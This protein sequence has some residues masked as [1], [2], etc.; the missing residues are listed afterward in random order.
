MTSTLPVRT[1]LGLVVII[2]IVAACGG[3]TGGLGSVP[4]SAPTASA[5]PTSPDLTPGPSASAGASHEPT[6]STEPTD[7]PSDIPDAS[8]A[9]SAAP[10]KS[11]GPA[12]TMIVRAYFVLGGEPGAVGLVP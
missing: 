1:A 11:P 6:E 3:S 12:G 4:T 9:P 8:T 7:E 5:E 10:A 2:A